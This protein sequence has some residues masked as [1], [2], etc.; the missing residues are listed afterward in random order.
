MRCRHSMPRFDYPPTRATWGARCGKSARRVLQGGETASLTQKVIWVFW[1]RAL[2]LG[3]TRGDRDAV[4]NGDGVVPH[5]NVFNHEAYD[6]LAFSDIKRFSSTA[7]ASEECGEGLDQA[8]ECSPIVSLVSDRLQ[9]HEGPTTVMG[10][11]NHA[12]SHTAYRDS[13]G[14]HQTHWV[15]HLPAHVFDPSTGKQGGHQSHAGTAQARL[16]S[17]HDGHLYTSS[18]GKKRKVQ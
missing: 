2:I 16:L 13:A 3:R 7:Q 4:T 9:L 18:H 14:N 6:S 12:Q 11:R 8:Q 5:E 10:T 15:A 17:G 1:L